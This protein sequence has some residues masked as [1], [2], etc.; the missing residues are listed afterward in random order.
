MAGRNQSIRQRL[1]RQR[2][3]AGSEA[4]TLNKGY[5]DKNAHKY[6]H[7]V[8]TPFAVDATSLPEVP[9]PT[10]V[11]KIAAFRAALATSETAKLKS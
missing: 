9:Q 1:H 7:F 11:E 2:H 6:W 10:I 3:S 5:T 4:P 8:D